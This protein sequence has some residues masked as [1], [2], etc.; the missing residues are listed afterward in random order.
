[1]H[2]IS[3]KPGIGVGD[4]LQFSSVPENYFRETG[5]KLI[6]VSR[7]W[8]FDF[9]PYVV[10][11]DEKPQTIRE[12][13]NFSPR[14]YDFPIPT[15]DEH[16]S[17]DVYHSNAE[18]HSLVWGVKPTLIRPRLYRFENFPYH[19]RKTILLHIDGKS[20]GTLPE[21]IIRH[22]I[23]KYGPTGNLK[24]IGRPHHTYGLEHIFTETL[25]DLAKVISEASMLIGADSGP[26][27]IAAC[28]PDV[29]V[30]KVRVRPVTS[31][32]TDW[33]PLAV[34]NFHAHWDDRIFQIFNPSEYD[35]GPFQSYRKM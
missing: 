20:H 27:W 12:M 13:W 15:G 17:R 35:A 31:N 7:P 22:V 10:R 1:M 25:W 23:E 16:R 30:K 3:I 9:N 33:T 28:Y 8:F 14:R 11:T 19:S 34:K 5:Q 6:D 2:G 4:G 21:H 24:L 26:S 29:I 32:Y 18:I